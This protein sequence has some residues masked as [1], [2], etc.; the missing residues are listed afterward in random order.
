MISITNC[1][2][3]IRLYKALTKIN[4]S[5]F[6]HSYQFHMHYVRVC[7]QN[8]LI[9]LVIFRAKYSIFWPFIKKLRNNYQVTEKINKPR[10]FIVLI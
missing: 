8:I 9:F 5:Y 2:E 6:D 7:M 10:S 3:Q 1:F 4:Q